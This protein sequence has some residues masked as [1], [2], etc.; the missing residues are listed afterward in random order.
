MLSVKPFSSSS[1]ASKYYAQGDYYG[2]EGKGIWFGLGAKELG[3]D[4]EFNA[5]E[6]TA[7]NHLLEGILTN[8]QVLG[9]K[10]KDGIEHRP[11]IDLTFSVPKSFSIQML[12]NAMEVEKQDLEQTLRKA[13]NSTLSYIEEKGY[14]I[15]R[16]GQGGHIKEEINKLTFATFLHTTN[17]NLEPQAHIHCFLA[18]A[19][20]CKDDK[21]RSLEFAGILQNNKFLGQVFRN[22][23][24]IEVK[25]LGINITPTILS[26]GSSSFELSHIN[27]K[28]IKGFSTRRKE[29]EELCK[30]Y[31]VTTKEGR[32]KIV[33][34]SRKSKQIANEEILKQ[35][36]QE[37]A[38]KIEK[39]VEQEI[40]KAD[41]D[42][43]K[44]ILNSNKIEHNNQSTLKEIVHLSLEDIT[45]NQT[46]FKWED[47]L[48]KAMK[49]SIGNYSIK[50]I[51]TEC[52]QLKI[53]KLIF[54]T[55]N[56]YTS[57]ALLTQEKQILQ[58]AKNTINISKP[59][60]QDK[61]FTAHLEKFQRRETAK[62]PD[63][64]MNKQQENALK[65]ILCSK[66]KI[67]MVEGLPGV[68]K[69]TVLNAVRDISNRKLLSLIGFGPKFE[70]LAP[71][72]SAAKTLKNSAELVN[73]NTIH[74]FLSRYNGYIEDRG[75]NSL[76]YQKQEF[77]KTMIFVDECSLISTNVMWKLL[78]LQEKFGFRLVLTG[79][80][81]QLGAVEAGKPF[82]QMLQVLPS[83]KMTDILR[84]Q[85]ESH[86]E[87]VVNVSVGNINKSFS[88][89][90]DNIKEKPKITQLAKEAANLFL[91]K[92]Q[93]ARDQT[94]LVSPTRNLRDQVNEYIRVSLTKEGVLKGEIKDK[95]RSK[96][97]EFQTLRAKDMSLADYQFAKS[98]KAN[99]DI[100][101]FNKN[102]SNGI[103]KNEC[104]RVKQINPIT[105]SLELVKENG[106]EI[107][108]NLR[109]GVD[110]KNKF[111]V[112]NEEVLKLQAGLK[113]MFTKNNQE[114][115][116]INSET[117]I[118]KAIHDKNI[119]LQ[120][121][122]GRIRNIPQSELKHIAYGYCVTVHNSQGK[123]YDNMIAAISSHKLLNNQKSWLVTISR[124]RHEFT[125][126]VENK[127][128]LKTYLLKNK[129]NEISALELEK[130]S[131]P[132]ET[133][134][135]I[136]EAK[137]SK[138]QAITAKSNMEIQI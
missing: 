88:I 73:S 18:N 58:Y 19:A 17:R 105:N 137:I 108:F 82:E 132:Q 26:D 9:K 67:I 5:K 52:E 10:T 115:G 41:N 63:F 100:I 125:A 84:Q 3:F 75:S 93:A 138:T 22:E 12:V 70:G 6:N 85:N 16:K 1:A 45:Y 49:F 136:I 77:K 28:L 102:Y 103:K 61:Y 113:I 95:T 129:G 80:T 128:Q 39:E 51:E 47:L 83:A 11:G 130:Q 55:N 8:G 46:T 120:F 13:V 109:K 68:G 126:L 36:W 35:A 135:S 101:R 133:N 127:D 64:I 2:S 74:S 32:D 30:L 121:E 66:D 65:H 62:N 33:I 119:Q 71:T 104:L 116:L 42:Q 94:L 117:A 89:H 91:S 59:I 60:I 44:Q 124:H 79:D 27:E 87:S 20:R 97:L 111:E 56:L 131:Y 122:D 86:K 107:R 14:V 40:V 96:I 57:K 43:E 24:A 90:Q 69:S 72:A 110:Y 38:Q 53:D 78:K 106:K 112:Y 25:K 34:N 54:G 31:G 114:F 92:S 123:T 76:K 7:F 15:A 98:Y 4:G 23:L 48:K 37:L 99:E 134:Q 50:E 118:I 21:Y 29:I 81:K